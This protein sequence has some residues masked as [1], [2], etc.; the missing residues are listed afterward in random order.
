M[1]P[2]SLIAEETQEGCDWGA[3]L[4][5]EINSCSMQAGLHDGAPSAYVCLVS[6]QLVGMAL[7]GGGA[8][9]GAASRQQ[10]QLRKGNDAGCL[11]RPLVAGL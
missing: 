11:P 3:L 9:H 8:L 2:R 6:R 1:T 7:S 5:R 4:L 10:L